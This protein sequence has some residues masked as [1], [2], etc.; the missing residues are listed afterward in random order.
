MEITHVHLIIFI[1][2]PSPTSI[3]QAASDTTGMHSTYHTRGRSLDVRNDKSSRNFIHP[4]LI[5]GVAARCAPPS[6]STVSHT[7][8]MLLQ[9]HT[10]LHPLQVFC[11]ISFW[12]CAITSLTPK[13]IYMYSQRQITMYITILLVNPQHRS[14]AQR[15]ACWT[16]IYNGA[17]LKPSSGKVL[18][19]NLNVTIRTII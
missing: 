13:T 2:A 16:S 12:D 4:F 15:V 7:K 17:G 6:P 11:Y 3:N 9:I 1:S 8:Q 10:F 14:I 18:S 19:E 5:L